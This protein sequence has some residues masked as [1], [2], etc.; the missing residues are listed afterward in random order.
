MKSVLYIG[1]TSLHLMWTVVVMTAALCYNTPSVCV[2]WLIPLC[3][4]CCCRPRPAYC[5]GSRLGQCCA[6][7]W[8]YNRHAIVLVGG[9]RHKGLL[10]CWSLVR[11]SVDVLGVGA[12]V[13]VGGLVGG[14]VLT[15]GGLAEDVQHFDTI[16][17][18]TTAVAFLFA[19]SKLHKKCVTL[20][21]EAPE[22]FIIASFR[23]VHCG[24][25]AFAFLEDF[26]SCDALAEI[27]T[28]QSALPIVENP[29]VKVHHGKVFPVVFNPHL[30]VKGKPAGIVP[31]FHVKHVDFASHRC[32]VVVGQVF[33]I[34]D[35]NFVGTLWHTVFLFPLFPFPVI[36]CVLVLVVSLLL[37]LLR[38]TLRRLL[39][40]FAFALRR[41][42]LCF[43]TLALG[44]ALC[45]G[46]A[47][48]HDGGGLGVLVEGG[49]FNFNG[50]N[51]CKT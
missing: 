49:V 40:L 51:L 22:E 46:L 48:V 31:G 16:R 38:L 6:F 27:F 35:L 9:I 21:L 19:F 43:A 1:P 39:P 23:P 37:L 34:A 47:V 33:Q 41:R 5:V 2:V 11:G 50:S 8:K 29:I 14:L 20:L 30:D 28:A 3:D 13:L 32:L 4:W 12:V 17:K 45:L 24:V 7:R 42:F 36:G 15:V 25:G 44:G 26:S 18:M 10:K